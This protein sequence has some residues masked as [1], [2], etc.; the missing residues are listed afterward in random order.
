MARGRYGRVARRPA[1]DDVDDD[2]AAVERCARDDASFDVVS[3]DFVDEITWYMREHKV[4]RAD[5][6]DAMGV[7]TGRVSRLLSGGEGL[8][9]RTLSA[10]LAALGARLEI[11]LRPANEHAPA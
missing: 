4:S 1:F 11:T 7:S 5:L 10:V 8:T 3:L 6:A 2:G 9:P